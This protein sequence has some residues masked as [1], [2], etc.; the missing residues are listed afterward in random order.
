MDFKKVNKTKWYILIVTNVF[1]FFL[2][3]GKDYGKDYKLIFHLQRKPRLELQLKEVDEFG[4]YSCP[5]YKGT[6]VVYKIPKEDVVHNLDQSLTLDENHHQLPVCKL[7]LKLP[8]VS[9]F[10][11]LITI[12]C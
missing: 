11:S 2:G 10:T 12:S 1:Y 9:Y 4:N 3:N 7:P 5:Y 6:L 8:K